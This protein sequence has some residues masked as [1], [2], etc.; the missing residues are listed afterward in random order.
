MEERFEDIKYLVKEAGVDSPSSDLLKNVMNHVEL[1]SAKQSFSY[2]PLISKKSGL[3]I[4][5]AILILLCG[6][7]YFSEGNESVMDT[8]DFSM[9]KANT[10][11]NPFKNFTLHKTSIY[12]ILFLT[13]L[14]FVQI[15]L[16]KR[17]IDKNFSS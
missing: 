5:F 8:I 11:K 15:P 9:L 16:L 10:V 1:S 13:F 7:F 4:A 17:R 3:L 12:G 6:L 2:T 14:F